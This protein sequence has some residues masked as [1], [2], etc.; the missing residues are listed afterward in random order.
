MVEIVWAGHPLSSKLLEACDEHDLR[1][2]TSPMTDTASCMLTTACHGTSAAYGSISAQYPKV[3][4]TH[5][6]QGSL[7]L[8]RLL[9]LG[10]GVVCISEKSRDAA[11]AYCTL[12]RRKLPETASDSQ[13][14]VIRSRSGIAV[15]RVQAQRDEW[16]HL[17][18]PD[19]KRPL[20][21]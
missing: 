17:Q 15:A 9:T 11:T 13:A 14:G 10:R 12:K 20:A 8:A 4:M 21:I 5:G 19:M 7:A 1:Q 2:N 18:M 16:F 6:G 3:S